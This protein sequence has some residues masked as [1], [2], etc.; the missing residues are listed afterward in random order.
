MREGAKKMA[1]MVQ[2][3]VLIAAKRKAFV[4]QMTNYI[5]DRIR[6]LN[7][8]KSELKEE[9]AWIETTNHR[10]AA[11]AEQEKLARYQDMAQCLA[12]KESESDL[13]KDQQSASL[14]NVRAKLDAATKNL[15]SIK[16]KINSKQDPAAPTF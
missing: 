5:N 2:Q 8:V 1:A 7:K 15:A 10:I 13:K 3:E 11:V 4:E 9:I 14:A 6:E 12:S 16:Q